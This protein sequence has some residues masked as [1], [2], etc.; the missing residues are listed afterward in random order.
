MTPES[1]ASGNGNNY[2]YCPL[3]DK[4]NW[5]TKVA[6]FLKNNRTSAYLI[7]HLIFKCSFP[8]GLK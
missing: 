4:K 1:R 5:T 7:I 2:Y 8:S 3:K 6:L